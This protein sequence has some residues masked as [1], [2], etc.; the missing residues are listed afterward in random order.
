MGAFDEVFQ[1]LGE[2]LTDIFV[3][4]QVTF[5]RVRQQYDPSSGTDVPF[6]ELEVLAKITPPTEFSI[7]RVDNKNVLSQDLLAYA[8]A[9]PL[10]DAGFDP[11]PT[12]GVQILI[13]R[14][15][16]V[17]S[18]VRTKIFSGGDSDALYELHLRP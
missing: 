1:D 9:K 16:R 8:P 7:R 2:S 6:V 15:T 12:T 18:V 17:Y 4:T 10:I 13:T 5:Q 3:D 11:I 14:G